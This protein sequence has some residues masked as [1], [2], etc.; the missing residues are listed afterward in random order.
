MMTILVVEDDGFIRDILTYSLK[1]EGF[2]VLEACDGREAFK[3]INN[4]KFDLA[5]LDVMLPDT[6]GFTICK[7]IMTNKLAPVIMLT[8]KSDI[9]D[10]LMGLDLGA[11]DYI[12]K[13]FDIREVIARINIVLRR[14]KK[15]EEET[16]NVLV[17]NPNIEIYKDRHEV[18]VNGEVIRLKRKEFKLLLTLAENRN[19]VLSREKLLDMVWGYDFEGDFRTIDVHIQRLRK[20]LGDKKDGS[21]IQTVF[22]VGYKMI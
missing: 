14:N 11:E 2:Q 17:V 3:I 18:K 6:D 20:K 13:P 4:N 21:I 8:A 19:R 15:V 22:G 9:S 7:K 12:L 10:K 16:N 1:K 5:L